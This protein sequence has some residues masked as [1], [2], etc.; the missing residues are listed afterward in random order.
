MDKPGDIKGGAAQT[1]NCSCVVV[2][3]SE[4]YARRNFPNTFV[5]LPPLVRPAA[6]LTAPIIPAI[7]EQQELLGFRY[8]KTL[9]EA[10]KISSNILEQNTPLR[11]SKIFVGSE[12]TLEKL[13]RY[14]DQLDKLTKEYKLSPHLDEKSQISLLYQS[15]KKSYGFVESYETRITKINFGHTTATQ[16]RLAQRV[17]TS[18]F[19]SIYASKSKADEEN[20]DLA[21]LID[22]SIPKCLMPRLA[23]CLSIMPSLHPSS[24]TKGSSL[25]RYGE[26][27]TEE[28]KSEKC[29]AIV[30]EVL[31]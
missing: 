28:K 24:I 1:V 26:F 18:G 17:D 7:A 11:V 25:E 22:G 19:Y 27:I 2:Y 4:S 10:K 16:A 20:V 31:E 13:N 5:G 30:T 9:D 14:N 23:K 3:I 6:P 15:T 8:A 21:T 29:C 12:M